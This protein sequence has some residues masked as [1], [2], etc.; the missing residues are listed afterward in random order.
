M[1][2]EI[3]C[4]E[5]KHFLLNL[6]RETLKL[7]LKNGT[8]PNV[9]EKKI[10]SS[11]LEKNGC[12]VTLHYKKDHKLR[13]CIG[14]LVPTERLY[15]SIIENSINA[16]NDPRFTPLSLN[17]I[18]K[19]EIEISVLTIPEKLVYSSTTQLLSK[20]VPFKDGVILKYRYYKSTFL[21]QVWKSLPDKDVFL[22][23]LALKGGAPA[24]AWKKDECEILIYHAEVFSE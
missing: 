23:Q 15:N 7:Y 14:C 17:E 22:S 13:G 2:K 21:P 10:S 3:F 4:L 24:D 9:D 11:L 20:L 18:D 19:I 5:D 16:A 1:K 12:F 8:R 6:A